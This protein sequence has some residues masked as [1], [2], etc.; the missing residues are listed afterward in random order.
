VFV[1]CGT[2]SGDERDS[3]GD[4][5]VQDSAGEV[6]PDSTVDSTADSLDDTADSAPD[7][8]DAADS[9]PDTADSAP[10]TAD[11]APDTDDHADSADSAD[12]AP[13]SED[14]SETA[15][16][17]DDASEATVTICHWPEGDVTPELL[18]VSPTEAEDYF[19]AGDVRGYVADVIFVSA[20]GTLEG[21]GTA[22]V[23]F[24]RIGDALRLVRC[25]YRSDGVHRTIR[26]APGVYRLSFDAAA[27][28]A[29]PG[30]DAAP[31]VIDVPV[32]LEGA[33]GP[34]LDES[35]VAVAFPGF[36]SAIDAWQSDLRAERS[37][38]TDT[39]ICGLCFS[40]SG[41]YEVV[42][43]R[44][45]DGLGGVFVA[46]AV[47]P[48]ALTVSLGTQAGELTVPDVVG[49]AETRVD[50]LVAGNVL[51]RH[52]RSGTA[53]GVRVIAFG[54]GGSGFSDDVSLIGRVLG[55][56]I[57]TPD[58]SP[59]AN[60]GVLVDAGFSD[61]KSKPMTATL[62]VEIADNTI[63]AARKP[64]MVI[65][66][67]A[68]TITNAA[69]SSWK[70]NTVLDHGAFVLDTDLPY[71]DAFWV[72]H[73]VADPLAGNAHSGGSCTED[74]DCASGSYRG[75]PLGG[76]CVESACVCPNG[77]TADEQGLCQDPTPVTT[78]MLINGAYIAPGTI[79]P[80]P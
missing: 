44:V 54:R 40:G 61:R 77:L 63:V 31:L 68:Q 64:V 51:T 73:F 76:S 39:D 21:V 25:A 18:L 55:N 10:D 8:E 46:G 23:P 27:L 19:A 2:D 48:S 11:S 41:R 79:L 49:T 47:G 9:A 12:S 37:Y 26:A 59:G 75:T 17:A 15:D 78:Q 14:A 5:E 1:A 32:R 52:F 35:G 29:N 16:T 6:A 24:H 13:D 70:T 62:V 57:A 65:T 66:T 53:F 36:A 43:N 7:T 20:A 28:E 56:T 33:A 80:A 60:N 4:A 34:A 69:V 72:D 67:R 22:E 38:A 30:Y 3:A 71:P 45:E 74:V 50:F 58:G 42:S